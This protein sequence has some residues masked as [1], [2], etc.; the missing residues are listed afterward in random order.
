MSRETTFRRASASDWDG[1]AALLQSAALP[2]EGAR[3]HLEGFVLAAEGEALVGCAAIERYQG[4]GL[5]RSVAVEE[6]ARGT[7]IGKALVEQVLAQARQ[8]GLRRIVLLTETAAGYFP[9]F[10]FRA[11]ARSQVP[12]EALESVEFKTAC[13]ESAA[14][15]MM[16]L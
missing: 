12:A 3:E 8:A 9:R 11:I 2:I 4:T 15:M 14:A 10:G 7:G 5:L 6:A 16:E 13:C 1:I